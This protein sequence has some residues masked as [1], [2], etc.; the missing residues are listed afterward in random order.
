MVAHGP[1][2]AYSFRWANG[3]EPRSHIHHFPM[4]IRAIGNGVADVHA[5]AEPDC[6]IGGSIAIVV[7]HLLLHG[8]RASNCTVYAVKYDEQGVARGLN[9]PSAMLIDRWVDQCPTKNAKPFERP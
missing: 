5:N 8:D 6:L 3:F 7:G 4:Q 1:R 2:D 9:D